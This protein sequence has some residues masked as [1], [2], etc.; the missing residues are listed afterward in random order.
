MSAFNAFK[1]TKNKGWTYKHD[2]IDL[3]RASEFV[4]RQ[5]EIRMARSWSRES[6]KLFR[7]Q[8]RHAVI[9]RKSRVIKRSPLFRS[10]NSAAFVQSIARVG[11]SI[12]PAAT[13]SGITPCSRINVARNV[14]HK[15]AYASSVQKDTFH[16]SLCD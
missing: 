1:K 9:G 8:H 7:P 16:V 15:S 14:T 2:V 13:L 3:S 6:I 4:C 10:A 11:I 5:P 12:K